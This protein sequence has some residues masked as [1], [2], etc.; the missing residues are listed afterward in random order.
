[1]RKCSKR[2]FAVQTTVGSH[3]RT[4]DILV[5][6]GA[7]TDHVMMQF[8]GFRHHMNDALAGIGKTEIGSL[9]VIVDG[10]GT[11][12]Q[13]VSEC[14]WPK[15][16]QSV[17][18]CKNCLVKTSHIFRPCLLVHCIIESKDLKILRIARRLCISRYYFDHFRPVIASVFCDAAD[19]LDSYF[20]FGTWKAVVPK[21]AMRFLSN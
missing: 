19:G 9:R 18:F 21:T 6:I 12:I 13:H 11:R 8:A 14:K 15:L 1:M 5:L 3:F 10:R 16:E 17:S 2:V 20:I 4:N 7:P